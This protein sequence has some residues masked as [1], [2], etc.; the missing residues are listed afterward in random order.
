MGT[1]L[2]YIPA[3]PQ[4]TSTFVATPPAD[5]NEGDLW[6]FTNYDGIPASTGADYDCIFQVVYQYQA[7][8][9]WEPI[10][11]GTAVLT[12]DTNPVG[13]VTIDLTSFQYIDPPVAVITSHSANT[14][15]TANFPA[16]TNI[17]NN[18][19]DVKIWEGATIALLGG[20]PI[21]A[22]TSQKTI[23]LHITGQV[24]PVPPV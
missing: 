8:L 3:N 16:I 12:G 4:T 17:A 7:S 19:I 21:Q 9:M 6:Y 2:T 15:P 20:F 11:P 13:V 10:T 18:K 24:Q 5:P 22:A 1:Y 14:A 23:D